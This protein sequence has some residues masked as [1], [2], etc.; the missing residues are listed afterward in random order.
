MAQRQLHRLNASAVSRGA[1][2]VLDRLDLTN[3]NP[4]ADLQ[5]QR[6]QFTL[7]MRVRLGKDGFQLI[8]RRLPGYFQLPGGDTG[9]GATRDDAGELRF[10]RCQ[11][12]CL[13]DDRGRRPWPW[14][15]GI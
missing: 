3:V 6:D 15:Q 4:L 14:S 13:C 10:R 5:E 2:R 8:A 1:V 9:R 7:A 12:E 11:A